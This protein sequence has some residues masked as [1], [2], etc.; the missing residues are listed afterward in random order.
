M[1]STILLYHDSRWRIAR[2]GA[3]APDDFVPILGYCPEVV[4]EVNEEK[5]ICP[6]QAYRH[7]APKASLILGDRDRQ[8]EAEFIV[9][10]RERRYAE[11]KR[12]IHLG[13]IEDPSEAAENLYHILRQLDIENA[14]IVWVDMDFPREGLWQTIAERLNRASEK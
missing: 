2:L 1:E 10:F 3:L 5:P 14:A 12:I 6:G 13:S 9:G 7:Y 8:G 11:G 4:D